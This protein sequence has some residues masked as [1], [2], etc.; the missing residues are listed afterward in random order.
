MIETLVAIFILTMAL[1][2]A[3]GLVIYAFSRSAVSQSE[4]IATN[5]AREGID[6]IRMM[7]DSNWLASDAKNNGGYELQSCTDIPGG[8]K[9]CYPKAYN[10]VPPYNSYDIPAG[11][12]RVR[13]NPV[14][15]AWSTDGTANY[16]LTLR[17]DGIYEHQN[18]ANT[19]FARMVNISFV[20]GGAF[21]PNNNNSNGQLVIRSV[22]AWRD[23][24][25]PSFA[26]GQD[27]L[28]LNSSCKIILEESLTNWKDYR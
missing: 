19:K 17:A 22:V 28:A 11:N 1:T 10:Q 21:A 2:S 27:L 3:L 15:K 4:I 6:V 7:R 16:N 20:F 23:K 18:L 24:N 9:P 8:A 25:C 12:R 26:A 14:T 13:F 5:L